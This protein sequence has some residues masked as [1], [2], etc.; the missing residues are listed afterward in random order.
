LKKESWGVRS[1]LHFSEFDLNIYQYLITRDNIQVIASAQ[2]VADV[3][4]QKGLF[5]KKKKRPV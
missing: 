5:A 3:Q 2:G 4:L 1:K